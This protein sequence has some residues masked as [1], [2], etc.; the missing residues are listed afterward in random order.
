ML[1]LNRSPVIAVL[2]CRPVKVL[3]RRYVGQLLSGALEGVRCSL[4]PE[5]LRDR[6][7]LFNELVNGHE[8]TS[9]TQYQVVVLHFHDDLL[10]E[11][12]VVTATLANEETLHS[13]LRICPVDELGQL[14]IHGVIFLANV[15]KVDFV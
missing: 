10:R 13:L 15:L 2:S 14:Y 6:V 1:P 9:D 7:M 3:L 11:V 8:T 5:M 4:V 12:A